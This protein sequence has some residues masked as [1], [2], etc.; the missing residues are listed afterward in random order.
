LVVHDALRALFLESMAHKRGKRD[1]VQLNLF[2]DTAV[3]HDGDRR[4]DD[5][6]VNAV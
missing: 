6:H 2:D 5:G 3:A 4:R 1:I